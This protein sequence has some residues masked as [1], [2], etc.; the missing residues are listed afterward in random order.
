MDLLQVWQP[1]GDVETSSL[2][3]P[4][5]RRRI[6]ALAIVITLLVAPVVFIYCVTLLSSEYRYHH[7]R[8]ALAYVLVA[9]FF[10][11]VEG[12][13]WRSSRVSDREPMWLGFNFFAM[14]VALV[15]GCAFGN[16]QYNEYMLPYYNLSSLN[17]Y[18]DVNVA[19]T[20]GD[21]FLDAGFIGFS[22]GSRVDLAKVSVFKEGSLYCVAPIVNMNANTT[23][24]TT[25]VY[26]FWAVGKDCCQDGIFRCGESR[27]PFARSGLREVDLHDQSQ[28]M[29]AVKQAE[30][31]YGLSTRYPILVMWMTN[32]LDYVLQFKVHGEEMWLAA[33]MGHILFNTLCIAV[34]AVFFARLGTLQAD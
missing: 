19:T 28:Y 7:P 13:Y 6:N 21:V 20:T 22:D 26:D 4:G 24:P 14:A 3:V 30:A 23:V 17:E 8:T 11:W 18:P 1:S 12:L 2:F 5:K 34:A 25:G 27:N 32:P 16:L 9:A 15:A 33:V 29:N 31:K 10:V